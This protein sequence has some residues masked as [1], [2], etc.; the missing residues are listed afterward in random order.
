MIALDFINSNSNYKLSFFKHID[1]EFFMD[2][3]FSIFSILPKI[4]VEKN[5][6]MLHLS[7]KI[8]CCALMSGKVKR[9]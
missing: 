8:T 1:P 3:L 2:K 7:V 4:I 9:M 6:I 5:T